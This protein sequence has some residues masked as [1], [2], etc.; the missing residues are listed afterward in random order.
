[1]RYLSSNRAVASPE[2]LQLKLA[3]LA[4]ERERLRTSGAAHESL[5]SN[6]LEIGRNQYELS[7]ALIRRH[8]TRP[9]ERAA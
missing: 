8:L 3:L 7:L 9:A 4:C 6:R 1:M 2:E 5:E